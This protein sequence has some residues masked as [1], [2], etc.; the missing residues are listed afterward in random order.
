[1]NLKA[2]M[3]IGLIMRR[4]DDLERGMHFNHQE[5][6]ALLRAGNGKATTATK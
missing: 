1:V 2:E 5:Q 3:E 6:C 4:L